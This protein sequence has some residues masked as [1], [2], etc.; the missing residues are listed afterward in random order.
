MNDDCLTL[1]LVIL[2]FIFI[3]LIAITSYK[4][5]M[6]EVYDKCLTQNGHMVYTDAVK[7]CKDFVYK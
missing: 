5:G 7:Y 6:R 1:P 2:G 3:V 4:M